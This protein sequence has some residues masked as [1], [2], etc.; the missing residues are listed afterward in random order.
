MAED[1]RFLIKLGLAS[2]ALAALIKYGG[3]LIPLPGTASVAL[4]IVLSPIVGVAL[5]LA[6]LYQPR[7][8]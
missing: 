1:A 8:K 5:W 3:P 2:A 7:P 4:A 6:W